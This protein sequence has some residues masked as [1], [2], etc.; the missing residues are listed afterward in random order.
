MRYINRR[1]RL[2][3]SLCLP[4][5]L[6]IITLSFMS[7]PNSQQEV[8]VIVERLRK[9]MIAADRSTLEGLAADSLS[10][11][12]SNGNVETKEQFVE[13]IASG[14]SDFTTIDL[15]EQTI[16]ISQ[17][18]AIVRHLFNA[19]TNDGGKPGTVKIKVLLVWQNQSGRWKLLAR[20][21]V[22]VV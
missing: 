20:Q 13:N 9:A 7:Q 15:S 6:F 21:A 3:I 17:D 18:T 8:E 1:W 22:K 14:R 16:S 4:L 2:L 19:T 5:H 12:H 11:G 10:Y